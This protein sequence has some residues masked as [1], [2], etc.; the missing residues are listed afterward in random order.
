VAQLPFRI[1]EGTSAVSVAEEEVGEVERQTV[2][3]AVPSEG[4]V[5][6]VLYFDFARQ[7]GRHD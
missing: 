5:E 3:C 7:R 1:H 4:V 6:V 2:E